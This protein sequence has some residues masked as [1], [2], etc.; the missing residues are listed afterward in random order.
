MATIS[1]RHS[2][3]KGRVVLRRFPP[4]RA[5]RYG[6]ASTH[7]PQATG[8]LGMTVGLS[9]A[10]GTVIPKEARLRPACFTSAKGVV[11]PTLR[12]PARTERYVRA[13]ISLVTMAAFSKSSSCDNGRLLLR[14]F[15]PDCVI[16]T[17]F[18]TSFR[19]RYYP[20]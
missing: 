3:I 7:P 20:R 16:Q 5:F 19:A 12:R 9:S 11:M 4:E 13:G 17:G 14:R 15:P 18:R 6:R 2:C 8:S 1:K 10:K